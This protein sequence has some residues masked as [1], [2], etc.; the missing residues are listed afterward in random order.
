[1][2]T[3]HIVA[4]L[5]KETG[6]L[7]PMDH[8]PLEV[9]VI[10]TRM[11][12]GEIAEELGRH[13]AYVEV[14]DD[15]SFIGDFAREMHTKNGLLEKCKTEGLPVDVVDADLFLFLSSFKEEPRQILLGGSSVHFDYRFLQHWMPKS[16]AHFSHRLVDVSSVQVT[17][18]VAC[19]LHIKDGF[20]APGDREHRV[21]A[22]LEMS[23]EM[24]RWQR[25]WFQDVT[26][27]ES[28][29]AAVV[30][31]FGVPRDDPFPGFILEALELLEGK[32]GVAK[33]GRRWS[34][35]QGK[36]VWQ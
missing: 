26:A 17:R 16:Y 24:Y 6:G 4:W 22:D 9:G 8:Q 18:N 30:T 27:L 5:D 2:P 21:F 29:L 14:M 19:G 20:T 34:C 36:L 35:R 3:D 12:N 1:M 28:A 11:V 10:V 32:S 25:S 15:G 7:D 23:M 31:S 13:H 33:D